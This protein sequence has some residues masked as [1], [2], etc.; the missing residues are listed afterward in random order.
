MKKLSATQWVL[1]VLS[2]ITTIVEM[3]ATNPEVFGVSN[4]L[5]M[6]VTLIVTMLKLLWDNYNMFSADNV[7]DFANNNSL[8]QAKKSGKV[9]AQDVKDWAKY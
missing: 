9:T 4:K 8:M 6:T 3:L 2:S 5:I 7:A 1:F